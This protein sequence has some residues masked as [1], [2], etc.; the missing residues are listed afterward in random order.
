MVQLDE[1]P[2]DLLLP[3]RV[4]VAGG[5][6]RE[7]HRG[8][9][10]D[11]PR[12]GHALLLPS[13]QLRRRVPLAPREPHV[14]QR[15]Q[16]LRPPLARGDPPVHQ[17]QL[18]VLRRGR[19]RQQVEAL[20]HEPQVVP[21][22]QRE[23]IERQRAHLHPPEPVRARRRPI[24]AAQ[25]VHAGRLAR[26]A[27][28]HHGHE[29]PLLD[30]QAHPGERAHLGVTA[31]VDALHVGQL[32]QRVHGAEV[33]AR[34]VSTRVPGCTAALVISVRCPSVEPTVTGFGVG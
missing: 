17:R 8:V 21:P 7:Q 32:D 23:L 13:G 26:P 31:P 16:R 10:H 4:Q 19:A 30:L 24:Q 1:Q 12:D 22:Q 27:R 3:R 18:H 5:L 2:H 20:E 14:G 6:V 29:L 9:G 34:S 28:P 11:R 15:L 33:S 25:D